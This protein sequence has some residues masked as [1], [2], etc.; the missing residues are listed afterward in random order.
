M[1]LYD[2]VIK[3]FI[4]ELMFKASSF[5]LST[6]VSQGFETSVNPQIYAMMGN[7]ALVKCEIPSFV[8]DFVSVESWTDEENKEY[9]SGIWF[10]MP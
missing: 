4:G 2:P 6:V 8:A 10:G 5:T 3:E 7:S 1:P 9:F